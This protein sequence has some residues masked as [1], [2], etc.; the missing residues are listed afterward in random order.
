[1][2]NSIFRYL[3]VVC[4]ARFSK[5]T[6]LDQSIAT[7]GFEAKLWFAA[8]KLRNNLGRSG[9]QARSWADLSDSFEGHFAKLVTGKGEFACGNPRSQRIAA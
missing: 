8:D 6:R 3:L 9:V 4:M 1:M 7:I 5:T 2:R